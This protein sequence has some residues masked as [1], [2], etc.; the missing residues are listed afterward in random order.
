MPLY[1]LFIEGLAPFY[2]LFIQGV[3]GAILFIVYSRFGAIGCLGAVRAVGRWRAAF[4]SES[5]DRPR[6]RPETF[7]TPP[8]QHPPSAPR[9][10]AVGIA[11]RL[12]LKKM[13]ECVAARDGDGEGGT[14]RVMPSACPTPRV[15]NM[16]QQSIF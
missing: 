14:R 8:P 9:R 11:P 10:F 13:A 4:F 15:H 16:D 12:F 1:L 3:L 2:L 7:T 6:P 5:A